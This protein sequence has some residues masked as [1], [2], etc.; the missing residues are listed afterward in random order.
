MIS[1]GSSVSFITFLIAMII[2]NGQCLGGPAFYFA[3]TTILA[4][5]PHINRTGLTLEDAYQIGALIEAQYGW[6]LTQALYY[7]SMPLCYVLHLFG[8]G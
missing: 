7:P 3:V 6:I 5:Y 2:L 4:A 1:G 8:W